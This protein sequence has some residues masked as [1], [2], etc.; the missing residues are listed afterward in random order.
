M[1]RPDCDRQTTIRYNK[2]QDDDLVMS[3][4]QL[5]LAQPKEKR[6]RYLRSAC[7]QDSELFKEVSKYVEWEELNERVPAGPAVYPTFLRGRFQAVRT[8]REPVPHRAR[9]SS[10]RDGHCLRSSR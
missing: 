3:L 2:A 4:V 7:A 8:S 6:E 9:S 1:R 5:A 10:R